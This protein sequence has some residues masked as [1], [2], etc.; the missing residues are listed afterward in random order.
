MQAVRVRFPIL[1][2]ELY[3]MLRNVDENPSVAI[4]LVQWSHFP[5]SSRDASDKSLTTKKNI[6]TIAVTKQN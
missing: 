1:G 3:F 2:R 4:V 6:A 5:S